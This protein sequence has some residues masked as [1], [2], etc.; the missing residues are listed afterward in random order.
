LYDNFLGRVAL[1]S[2]QRLRICRR[3]Q[4][5]LKTFNS[6]CLV[7]FCPC[8]SGLGRNAAALSSCS[9]GGL[10]FAGLAVLRP[11]LAQIAS[12]LQL[13]SQHEQ[14]LVRL[15][16]AT[17]ACLAAASDALQVINQ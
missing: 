16:A 14:Q 6:F 5:T 10:L 9:G 11:V 4:H 15:A 1:L 3:A 17:S 12:A 13:D 7:F 2:V 8:I